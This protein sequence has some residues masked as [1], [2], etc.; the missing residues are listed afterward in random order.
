MHRS[1]AGSQIFFVSRA[2]EVP[3]L[4]GERGESAAHRC[5]LQNAAQKKKE[6]KKREAEIKRAVLRGVVW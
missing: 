3:R 4:E 2:D 1:A 6:K 5:K